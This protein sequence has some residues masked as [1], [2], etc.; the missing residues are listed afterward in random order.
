VAIGEHDNQKLRAWIEVPPDER[1]GLRLVYLHLSRIEPA[2]AVDPQAVVRSL[3]ALGRDEAQI[4]APGKSTRTTTL[5][6]GR[7]DDQIR[8][9]VRPTTPTMLRRFQL[10]RLSN[11]DVAVVYKALAWSVVDRVCKQ[12]E[13][14]IS[15]NGGT[16]PV[17]PYD[18]AGRQSL[19]SILEFTEHMADITRYLDKIDAEASRER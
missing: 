2:A 15:A 8:V 1:R 16:I 14:R 6:L 7:A 12:I 17:D 19:H 18:S 13:E 3:M 11:G 9:A 4:R 10:F 5:E